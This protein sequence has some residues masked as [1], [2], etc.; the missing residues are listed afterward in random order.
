MLSVCSRFHK[1]SQVHDV[2]EDGAHRLTRV[3]ERLN[4]IETQ[5]RKNARTIADKT[6]AHK[7]EVIPV[8]VCN[9]NMVVFQCNGNHIIGHVVL[10]LFLL[11]GRELLVRIFAIHR[12]QLRYEVVIFYMHKIQSCTISFRF[13]LQRYSISCLVLMASWCTKHGEVCDGLT[14]R[15]K[16]SHGVTTI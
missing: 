1:T 12:T 5:S 15:I 8:L 11:R 16:R 13:C 6:R 9:E 3:M 2:R 4:V 10:Q 7:Y 14:S